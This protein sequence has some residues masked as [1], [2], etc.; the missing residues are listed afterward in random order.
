MGSGGATDIDIVS[1]D[2]QVGMVLAGMEWPKWEWRREQTDDNVI[3]SDAFDGR[4]RRVRQ[5]K[6]LAADLCGTSRQ[7]PRSPRRMGCGCAP[8]SMVLTGYPYPLTLRCT[9]RYPLTIQC[10][11]CW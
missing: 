2:A 3:F 7:H 1:S 5:H 9:L 4:K 6:L 11:E 8:S 10:S